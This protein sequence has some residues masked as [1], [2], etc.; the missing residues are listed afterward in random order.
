MTRLLTLQRRPGH[1]PRISVRLLSR[2]RFVGKGNLNCFAKMSMILCDF[3]RWF[4]TFPKNGIVHWDSLS[5]KG[6][7]KELV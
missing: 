4:E 6:L 2:G 3:I 7:R 5:K 1:A